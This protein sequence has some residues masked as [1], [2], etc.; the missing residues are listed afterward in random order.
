ML[1]PPSNPYALGQQVIVLLSHCLLLSDVASS[2]TI[3]WTAYCLDHPIVCDLTIVI[4]YTYYQ[5]V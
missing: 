1:N 3:V 2:Y 5:V 4:T